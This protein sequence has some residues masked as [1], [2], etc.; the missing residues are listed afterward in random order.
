MPNSIGSMSHS[1]SFL[2]E[3]DSLLDASED[4]CSFRSFDHSLIAK[5]F[6]TRVAD[7]FQK[8]E[9]SKPLDL[10]LGSSA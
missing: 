9:T 5:Y 10:F 2:Q 4:L 8:V 3:M 7:E 1:K 6:S